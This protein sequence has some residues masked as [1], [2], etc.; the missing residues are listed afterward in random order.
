M[1]PT[2]MY[3]LRQPRKTGQAW[4]FFNTRQPRIIRIELTTQVYRVV[5]QTGLD[6]EL[7]G[8]SVQ[9]WRS[10]M[11]R[12]LWSIRRQHRAAVQQAYK[13]YNL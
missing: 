1:K 8:L 3:W 2:L 12:T 10:V 4:E 9:G 13:S 5:I 7:A 6:I 11:A